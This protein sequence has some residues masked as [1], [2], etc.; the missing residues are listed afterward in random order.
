V[1][2]V[3]AATIE[4]AAGNRESVVIVINPKFGVLVEGYLFW[5]VGGSII[6]SWA[7]SDVFFHEFRMLK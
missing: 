3:Y 6:F 7:G 4:A 2:V 1:I 5:F